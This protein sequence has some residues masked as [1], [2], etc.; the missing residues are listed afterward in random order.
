MKTGDRV[1]I[2]RPDS[3]WSSGTL[4]YIRDAKNIRTGVSEKLTHFVKF[5]QRPGMDYYG[6]WFDPADLAVT[7]P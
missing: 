7:K 1:T 5:D 6:A 4:L 3:P 2:T